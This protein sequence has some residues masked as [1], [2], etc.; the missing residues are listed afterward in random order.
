MSDLEKK[1]AA[2]SPEKRKLLEK[3]LKQKGSQFNSF[4]LSF[5]QQRLW[6][7]DQLEPGNPAYNIPAA[8]RLVGL[9]DIEA[10]EKSLNEIVQRHEILRTTFT[11]VSGKAVQIID[12][13]PKV[14]LEKIR[15]TDLSESEQ[16]DRV[17]QI[18]KEKTQ[19]R[20]NLTKGPL[21]FITLLTLK[22]D[23]HILLM[24]MHHIISDGWSMGIII[25][26]FGA[27]YQAYV[28][29]QSAALPKLK[30]QY[31]DFAQWQRKWLSG[32]RL[33]K[34]LHF[35]KTQL[36]TNP[37]I[38]KLP[39]DNPRPA[40]LSNNGKSASILLPPEFLKKV[41]DFSRHE[42][43]T[44][45][46]AFLAVFQTLLYRYS[47]QTDIYIGTPIANRNRA[48]I[49]PV[50][51]FF[52]NTLVMRGDLSGKP[53]FNTYLQYVKETALNAYGH[54]D[55]PFEML[56][57]AIQPERNL[58]FS[59]I[60]QVMFVH[61]TNETSE[62]KL[63]GLTILPVEFENTSTKFDLTLRVNE[64][65]KGLQ[66]HFDYNADLFHEDTI[67]RMLSH[68][69]Y[70]LEEVVTNPQQSVSAI[71][72]VKDE[73]RKKL[74][75]EWNRTKTEFPSDTLIHQLFEQQVAHTPNRPAVFYEDILLTFK[76]LNAHANQ[77]AHKLMAIGAGPDTMVGLYMERSTE[78]LIGLLGILK[79]GAAYVPLDVAQPMERLQFIID[80]AA[81]HVLVS[82]SHLAPSL[83]HFKGTVLQIDQDSI[84]HESTENPEI[85]IL[86]E[87]LAYIIYT[88]GTTGKPKGI[89]IQHQSVI[90][91]N[92]AL[93][94][95]IY[96]YHKNGPFNVSVNGPLA[97][98]TSVKQIIQLL[99]GH[100]LFV[101]PAETRLDG[102]ALLKYIRRN[103]IHV[104]DCTP[105]QLR[106]LLDAGLT[107]EQAFMPELM[108]IGG[109]AIDDSLWE[110]LSGSEDIT[111]YNVYGPT[112]CTVDATLF[113]I[114]KRNSNPPKKPVIGKP[115]ANTEVF[116]LDS[117]FN[118][119]PVGIP[120][121]LCISGAGLARGYLNRPDLS[122]EKFIPNPFTELTGNRLYRTGD[123]ARFLPDGNIEFFGRID[124]QVKVRG[125]R[126]ELP[127]IENILLRQESIKD[128]V[129]LA[130]E[131]RLVAF[132]V[133]AGR[134]ETDIKRLRELLQNVLPDYMIPALFVPL[135]SLP[136]T[137]NGKVDRHAL[138][139]PQ[140]MDISSQ[141]QF[142]APRSAEEEI[143]A[144]IFAEILNIKNIGATD[145][146]FEIG[147][148]SL[149]AT[150]VISRITD[151]FK[152][153]L[154]L[155]D[156]FQAP[157]VEQ[158][159]LR[160]K[161]AQLRSEQIE[162]APITPVDR[163]QKLPLSFAQQRLWFLDQL[164]PG[165][166]FYNIPSAYRIS[167]KLDIRAL[168]ESMQKMVERHEIL[169]TLFTTENGKAY[170]HILDRLQVNIP[171]TDLRDLSKKERTKTIRELILKEAQK[172]FDLSRG[173]LFRTGIILLSDKE[174]VLL[175]TMHHII[176]DAWS[177]RIFIK[178]MAALYNSIKKKQPINLPAPEL[179][180]ADY[181]YWQ[182]NWLQGDVLEKQLRFWKEQL[183]SSN[184]TLDLPI[185]K[186]R[187]SVQT[188][189]GSH[190]AFELEP[191]LSE[192][193]K[194]FTQKQSATLFMTTLAAFNVLLF[195]Y[196]GQD[197]I[198]IGSP[199]ANRNR[200]AIENIIGF[201]VNTL[202]LRTDLSG[203]PTFIELINRIKETALGAF[204][205]QDVPFE[206]LLDVIH[207]DRNLS[208][209]P[210]FQ[211]MFVLQNTPMR[212]EPAADFD[213]EFIGVENNISQFDLTLT[214]NDTPQKI[215]GGFE[216][217]TDIFDRDSIEQMVAHFK[218]ILAQM[219]RHPQQSITAVSLLRPEESQKLTR[220]WN[221]EITPP[222]K[223]LCIHHLFERQ[224]R[225]TPHAKAVIVSEKSFTYEQLNNAANRLARFLHKRGITG[226]SRV[227]LCTER[228]FEMLVG[229]FGILKSGAAYVPLDPNYPDERLAFM[230]ED[231]RLDII[232]TQEHLTENLK[233]Q[234][235]ELLYLDKD[236]AQ[237]EKEPPT[238][239]LPKPL[240]A[241]NLAYI[242]Y[243]SGSTG[244]PKGVLIPHNSVVNHNLAMAKEFGLTSHDRVLQFATI[245]FDTA[246]E[247]IF[248]TLN[249]GGT[250]VLR[251]TEVLISGSQLLEMIHKHGISVI[252][253]PTAYW[254]QIVT[255]LEESEK[256]LPTSLRLVI[257]GGDKINAER[258]MAW[259]KIA[260]KKVRLLNTYGPTETTI[261]STL[262]ETTSNDKEMQ[263]PEDLPIGRPLE[264]TSAYVLDPQMNPVPVGIPG[265]LYTGGNGL[266]HG[267]LHRPDLTAEKF[268]PDPF[269]KFP[270]KRLYKTGDLVC[271][272][273]DGNI[274]FLGRVDQQVKIRGFRVEIGEIENLLNRYPQIKTS[275]VVP[276]QD[277]N[278]LKR[279]VAYFT[280]KESTA[281]SGTKTISVPAV[282]DFLSAKLPEYMVPSAFMQLD[283]IPYMP[284][285]KID[286]RSLPVPNEIRSSLKTEYAPPET[287]NEKII[288]EIMQEILGQKKIG[289]N[290]NFFE[291]GGDSIL[292]IQVV[293]R[294]SQKGLQ[295][296]QV[297]MFKYQTIAQL[298]AVASTAKIIDAEQGLVEGSLPL[299]PIQHWFFSQNLKRPSHWNQSL[300]FEVKQ[301]LDPT[302]LAKVT[303]ALLTHHDALRLRYEENSPF[304]FQI[305]AGLPETLPFTVFDGSKLEDARL[306]SFIERNTQALQRSINLQE[307]TLFRVAYFDFGNRP[308]R[309]LLIVH[310]LAMDGISWR[311]LLEDF[312][313]AYQQAISGQ[314][315]ILPR[316]TTSFK[317]WAEKLEQYASG[318]K[319]KSES[320]FWLDMSRKIQT[321][322][323]ADFPQGINTEDSATQIAV[324]LTTEETTSLLQEVPKVYNT[325]INDIL[326]S[327]LALAFAKWEGKRSLL[328]H[329]EGHGRENILPDVDISR[330]L[331]WFTTLYPV[332]LELGSAVGPGDTIKNIKELLR[333]IPEK[334]IGYGILRYLSPDD[335]IRQEL[336]SLD[337][338]YITFNYLGQF[339]QALPSESLLAPASERKGA[340]HDPEEKRSGLIDISGATADGK[341]NL[342]FTFS[343]NQFRSERIQLFG[344]TYIEQLR[345]L[346]RHCK[347]PE[348]GGRTASDFKLA[349]LDNKKLDKVMAQ[350]QK[351][352][353]RKKR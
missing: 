6:F 257:L 255:E 151:S 311:I 45:F 226:G 231:S 87:Q 291:L 19:H 58:T 56:V 29:K 2:L 301:A 267:Y 331:G 153:E 179:Q 265:E 237:I 306:K 164:E 248:P 177:M 312:Q 25:A 102:K 121:E 197:D 38:L 145:N 189:R 213:L 330:T 294:A 3:K 128:A 30:I 300:L 272:R 252:D 62:T 15:I 136:L 36:G 178:E 44:T 163:N 143:I 17:K 264:N 268:I 132:I 96:K 18:I 193:L 172:P 9:L 169:R 327:A 245:N 99:N 94:K 190:L 149:L 40:V 137:P 271:F 283:K 196:S 42:S 105:S 353:R 133:P 165:S 41:Q 22:K 110:R 150:Q 325:E 346:I 225:K 230:I 108:L 23:E 84:R 81:I 339:D 206:K 161:T 200:S 46:M 95:A 104:F 127:E 59:P 139:I 304:P 180:Y 119:A 147:G 184:F 162:S 317:E 340:E 182:R 269:S 171:Q 111:F 26:E 185:A 218:R 122:A 326:L 175:L 148:H 80:D 205:H 305:N 345:Q 238:S 243:T 124:H 233:G 92:V 208:H 333:R 273:K 285:G 279:L 194:A 204:S 337:R 33:E 309:L 82:Q 4:P 50:I 79:A 27:L 314:E 146:F 106:L 116:I 170:Q 14:L 186:T 235:A 261:I 71:K 7:L 158:L 263:T 117:Q 35:W 214:L 31:A 249:T 152:T 10:L 274:D 64:M 134:E 66:V 350:L 220:D 282:R 329:M 281:E 135:E 192:Q 85:H 332:L 65:A 24:V 232:L 241:E 8:F 101:V 115:V 167:G 88:S 210:L 323:V 338:T 195:R 321:P 70:L 229:L 221:H 166:P 51:G 55:L 5:A 125:Y 199:I 73:E 90:N 253:L 277:K 39:T 141:G 28:N 74:L 77:V 32:E 47:G 217:N 187:P 320:G 203:N 259:S 207:T 292:S 242:I 155:R 276:R 341:L 256:Q 86:P 168:T 198:N 83:S 11:A 130:I 118:P 250:L 315:I 57:D 303:N 310:H 12:K 215:S 308:G 63:P 21:G 72:L 98:D 316:K 328:I 236:W 254:H 307:G 75:Y 347:A 222:Q 318:E 286:V 157:T 313:T 159:A 299:T 144:G 60:F 174:F 52:V 156:I 352:K 334:G 209:S 270:G 20:F 284:N 258:F 68:Y 183:G 113:A 223:D 275:V 191:A 319:A 69:R 224:V 91:L 239:P 49:E 100:T 278:N 302:L 61:T 126:I 154:P 246:V 288:A 351:G 107:E 343:K 129:V 266:A 335:S 140:E 290:D 176:S 349:G 1:L 93:N 202:V 251:G 48:E 219:V 16:E 54:Q 211:V 295:I 228:S 336:S 181:A 173:P 109:E 322:F 344:E 260:D 262:Y 297:Q 131:Q 123:L 201:F 120:G 244:R 67:R 324:S 114:G 287:E 298:A 53:D 13:K 212:V 234:K 289:I 188:Y 348:A 138:R 216:Y 78:M 103:K 160:V 34:Q 227:G 342:S 97:F 112:E 89:A 43:V 293:A 280:A 296:T 247:E 142:V 76:E 240:D 37:A